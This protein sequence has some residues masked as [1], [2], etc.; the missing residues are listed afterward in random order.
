M[1]EQQVDILIV[2]GGLTGAALNL[3]LAGRGLSIR[4]IETNS[5]DTRLSP[6]FDARTIALSPASVRI[7]QML[8]VWPLLESHATAINTI[9][10]SD[11]YHFGTVNL[12]AKQNH[13]LGYVVEMQQIN[14]ALHQLLDPATIMAPASLIE[15]DVNS[16]VATIEQN[17]RASRIKAKLIVA[18]DGVHSSVRTLA[19]M[20]V[21]VKDYQQQAIVA[22]IGLNRSHHNYAYER[23]T[24]N[25]PLALLPMSE[26]RASLVWAV[27]PER[28]HELL[29]LDETQF[30]KQLQL[31][32]GYK[33]GRFIK[34]GK[35]FVY[36]LRQAIMPIQ[37][38][39]PLVFVGNAA[40]TLHPV[41]GQGFNL[42]LRDVATLAQCLIKDGLS[43]IMLGNYQQMRRYDQ[44]ATARFTD[45]LIAVFT[46][47]IPG[48]GMARS[49]GL[50]AV[51]NLPGLKALLTR[52]ARGFAG[53]VPDLVCGI[54][55]AGGNNET[56]I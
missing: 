35:R 45:S 27:K 13:S 55:L 52:H 1:A 24:A 51:D 49:L 16:A 44:Q 22:N 12:Q 43:A 53:T 36:P 11:Q 48:F 2:G 20:K 40:H 28:A 41:A 8:K 54:E 15:L 37:A 23:F 17:G 25:G 47:K 42:G 18:A 7:L 26:Q 56:A 32:F 5:F 9:H 31:T 34:A 50:M 30:L 29:K 3:A 10:V 6:D 39:W 38:A 4:L 19:N 33:A 14:R 46:N 21:N